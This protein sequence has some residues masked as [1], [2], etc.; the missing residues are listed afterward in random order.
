MVLL[1]VSPKIS[2]GSATVVAGS[3]IILLVP[4]SLLLAPQ[5]FLLAPQLLPAPRQFL[6][7][8]QWFLLAPQNLLFARKNNPA[9]CMEFLR[10]AW[11]FCGMHGFI[12]NATSYFGMH[13][14]PVERMEFLRNTWMIDDPSRRRFPAE[15][16]FVLIV[17]CISMTNM[18]PITHRFPRPASVGLLEF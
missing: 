2:F 5:Q 10:T 8:S 3:T 16:I 9:I 14:I 1:G 6:L 17:V 7:A 18:S 4:P 13:G 12:R 15:L 11:N